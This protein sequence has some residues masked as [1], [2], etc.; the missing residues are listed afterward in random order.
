MSTSDPGKWAESQARIWLEMQSR[1]VAEFTWH[2]YPDAKAAQGA[3]AAQPADYLVSNGTVCHLEIKETKQINRLP[4]SKVRQYG[5][6]KKW[7]L[8]KIEPYVVVYRSEAHD[9]TFLT[10]TDLCMD[11][12]APASFDMTKTPKFASC[13]DVLNHLFAT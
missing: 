5:Q 6:L 9:W 12:D 7:W 3:L 2:R 10:A 8:A 13:A 11:G 1:K 4:K